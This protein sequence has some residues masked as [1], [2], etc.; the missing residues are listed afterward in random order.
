MKKIFLPLMLV[1]SIV[2]LAGCFPK[3]QVYGVGNEGGLIFAVNPPEAE[4]LLDGVVQGRASDFNE[5]RYLK[6]PS[7]KHQLEIRM[8]GFEPYRREIYI[9]NSLQRIETALIQAPGG[10]R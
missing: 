4:V 6:V 7:G 9:S 8:P 2:L 1:A 3:G 5:E 10:G